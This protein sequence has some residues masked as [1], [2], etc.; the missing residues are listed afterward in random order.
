MAASTK[1]RKRREEMSNLFKKKLERAGEQEAMRFAFSA[2]VMALAYALRET[3]GKA[4][5]INALNEEILIIGS[6]PIDTDIVIETK[7]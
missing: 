2:G 6:E 3:G 4:E 5:L 7:H 1:L